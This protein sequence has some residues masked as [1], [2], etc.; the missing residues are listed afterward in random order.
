MA[1]STSLSPY[2][3]PRLIISL[4]KQK[5]GA[6]RSPLLTISVSRLHT[7]PVVVFVVAVYNSAVKMETY[8]VA[9]KSAPLKSNF[10]RGLIVYRDNG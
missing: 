1:D 5:P 8:Q 3:L 7:L 4:E 10:G 6:V 2:G 9:L